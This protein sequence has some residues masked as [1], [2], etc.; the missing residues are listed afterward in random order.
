MVFSVFPGLHSPLQSHTWVRLA[1]GSEGAPGVGSCVGPRATF[2]L[3]TSTRAEG[4]AT[5]TH[6]RTHTDTD[7]DTDTHIHTE[8]RTHKHTHTHTHTYTHTETHTYTHIHTQRQTHRQTNR[9]T[10]TH[11][12]TLNHTHRKTHRPT[13]RD[14]EKNTNTNTDRQRH[15]HTHREPCRPT[16]IQHLFM[17]STREALNTLTNVRRMLDEPA[18]CYQCMCLIMAYGISFSTPVLQTFLYRCRSPRSYPAP[19]SWP[20]P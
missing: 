18:P 8:T 13:H 15:T 19:V 3:N 2:R 7:T 12:H 20:N 14:T 10:H 11:S 9:D 4:H 1:G 5:D 16:F 6:T 17:F